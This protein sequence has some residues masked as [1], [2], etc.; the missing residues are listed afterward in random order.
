MKK[1]RLLVT[2]ECPK[3]C[4]GCCNKD[5][6]IDNLPKVE[7]FNYDEILITGG[8]P[9]LI[10]D[11]LVG[12]IMA[13]RTV[14][15]AKIYVYTADY[16]IFL[17]S[18]IDHVDGVTLTLHNQRDSNRLGNFYRMMNSLTSVNKDIIEDLNIIHSKSLRLNVFKGIVIHEDIELQ[19]WVVKKDIEWIE[20]RP[21]PKDEE[22]KRI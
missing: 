21:L 11:Y 3:K 9:M 12:Y 10:H 14:S 19:H 5:W 13:I 1:L 2:K 7:H 4:P 15:N 6:D 20:N 8:E 22:F 16:N 18:I 17:R